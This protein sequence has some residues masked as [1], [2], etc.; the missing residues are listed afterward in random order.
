MSRYHIT[1]IG[2]TSLPR[3]RAFINRGQLNFEA[4]DKYLDYKDAWHNDISVVLAAV[5]RYHG[6]IN[7]H[8]QIDIE[9]C[10]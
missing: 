8:C 6:R 3:F 1:E 10:Q 9:Y 4:L 2:N 5:A 7:Y